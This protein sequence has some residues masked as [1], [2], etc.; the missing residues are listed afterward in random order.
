[1]EQEKRLATKRDTDNAM[2]INPNPQGKA[3]LPLLDELRHWNQGAATEK[4]ARDILGDYL[5][6]LLVLSAEFNFRP[7]PGREYYLYYRAG[8]WQLSLL[9]PSD[10]GSSRQGDFAGACVLRP[11]ATWSIT[12]CET[13]AQREE[14]L[15]ALKAFQRAFGENLDSDTAMAEGLPYF[16]RHLPYYRKVLA[17]ALSHSLSTSLGALGLQHSSG[18]QLLS[19]Q[20]ARP[21]LEKPVTDW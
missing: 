8:H 10:W 19:R 11:D 4:S 6:S 15:S 3:A 12:L 16:E 13:L 17:F 5:A 14:L 7:V 21:S 18:R 20:A 2:K 1:M 9:S